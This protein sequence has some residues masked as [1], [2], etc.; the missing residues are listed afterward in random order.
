MNAQT[1]FITGATDGIGQLTAIDLAQQNKN[2]TILIHGRNRNKLDK[3]IEEVRSVNSKSA[4]SMV[5]LRLPGFY[6]VF[7]NF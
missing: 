5:R 1:I 3:V 6:I 4:L 2:A 7:F